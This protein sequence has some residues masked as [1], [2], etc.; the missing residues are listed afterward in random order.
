MPRRE[1]RG[2]AHEVILDAGGVRKHRE[3]GPRGLARRR[4]G[5][6]ELG[7]AE[8]PVPCT[9]GVRHGGCGRSVCSGI[10]PDSGGCYGFG[11][12][13]DDLLRFGSERGEPLFSFEFFP[14]KTDAGVEALFE[15]VRMLR[16]LGPSFVSVTWGAGGSTR[17][18]TLE[19]V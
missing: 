16:P 13:I 2:P 11:M 18:R 4:V 6:A 5:E 7:G 15:A 9:I 8:H 17:G 3:E 14:P 12:R 1:R 19:M 10:A